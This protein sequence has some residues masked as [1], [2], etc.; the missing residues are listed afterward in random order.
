MASGK[1]LA[2]QSSVGDLVIIESRAFLV[3]MVAGPHVTVDSV[4]HF[5]TGGLA[6]LTLV[7][8]VE[9]LGVAP[10]RKLEDVLGHVPVASSDVATKA[11]GHE[12]LIERGTYSLGS[13]KVEERKTEQEIRGPVVGEMVEDA[14]EVP[15][16][17]EATPIS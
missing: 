15:T 10:T 16:P 12:T 7:G 5:L 3:D 9:G 13:V 8:V 2:T 11:C 4:L 14:H 6:G 17:M 1:N